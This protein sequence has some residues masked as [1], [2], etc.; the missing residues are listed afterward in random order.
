MVKRRT[1]KPSKSKIKSKIVAM[2][3]GILAALGFAQYSGTL[4]PLLNMGADYIADII[5]KAPPMHGNVLRVFDG[6]TAVVTDGE[7]NEVTVRLYGVDAPEHGQR[8]GEESRS[9]LYGLIYGKTVALTV[10]DMDRYGRSVAIL[11]TDNITVNEEMLRAGMAWYYGAYCKK[12]FCGS[13][14]KLAAEAK[15]GRIGLW[16]DSRPVTPWEYRN[17]NK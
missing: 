10:I 11:E 15:A 3:L 14:E 13:W 16:K 1:S 9:T 8:Y 5:T 7:G 6:D 4:K 12:Y 2:V 17:E